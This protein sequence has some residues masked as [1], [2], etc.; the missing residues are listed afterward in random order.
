M[1][2]S[3][4]IQ[5]LTDQTNLKG[6][7]LIQQPDAQDIRVDL[8]LDVGESDNTGPE[9]LSHYLEHLVGWNADR[10]N[11]DNLHARQ[12]NAWANS[13]FTNYHNLGGQAQ[14]PKMMEFAARVFQ[15]VD[16]DRSFMRSERNIVEREFDLRMTENTLS[17]LH[18]AVMKALYPGHARGRSTIGSRQSIRQITVEDALNFHRATYSADRATLLISGNLDKQDVVDALQQSFSDLP[19]QP[20]SLRPHALPLQTPRQTPVQIE[21]TTTTQPVV[22]SAFHALPLNRPATVYDLAS[23]DLLG[24]VLVSSLD[25]GLNRP[26]Y[27]DDFWVTSVE[28]WINFH[29]NLH[30]QL[31]IWAR[32]DVDVSVSDLVAHLDTT[33]AKIAKQGIPSAS[34]ETVRA[35]VIA[36]RQRVMTDTNAQRTYAHLTARHLPAPLA[37]EDSIPLLKQVTLQDVNAALKRLVQ[38]PQRAT[39]IALPKE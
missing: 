10:A 26:L 13:F 7:F 24:A 16:L 18:L 1:A 19:V 5:D 29:P 34:F 28:S 20:T 37:L 27:F 21:T 14:L 30:P 4:T 32:P 39:G 33:L 12:M 11:K 9:G 35:D 22:L 8:F 25:G 31:L 15:P 3:Q 17:R 23:Y 2:W 36:T 6:A 38:S